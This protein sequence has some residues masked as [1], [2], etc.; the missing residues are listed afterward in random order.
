[1]VFIMQKD[2]IN[3][4]E[5]G[6]K[7]SR[8]LLDQISDCLRV[9]G[10]SPRT[11]EAYRIGPNGMC[12]SLT[13]VTPRKWDRPKSKSLSHTW[14]LRKICRAQLRTNRSQIGKEPVGFTESYR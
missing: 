8:K 11:E 9:K 4:N 12:F 14:P 1:M 10:Y 3:V 6:Y 13:S 5:H 7:L 2:Q